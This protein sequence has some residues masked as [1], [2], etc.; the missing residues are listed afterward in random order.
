MVRY[1]RKQLQII[2]II[3]MIQPFTQSSPST[4]YC[5][6]LHHLYCLIFSLPVQL[7]ISFVYNI[8][9]VYPEHS[10]IPD[11]SEGPDFKPSYYGQPTVLSL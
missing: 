10:A 2:Q 8:S 5:L 9:T 3:F 4:L 6:L 7:S 11:I 1:I